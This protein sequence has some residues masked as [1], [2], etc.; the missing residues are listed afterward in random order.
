MMNEFVMKYGVSIIFWVIGLF[1]VIVSYA[2][3]RT[4]SS[5]VPIVGGIII[6]IGGLLSPIKWLA[7]LCFVDYGFWYFPIS[8]ILDGKYWKK[9]SAR[10]TEAYDKHG[11]KKGSSEE[12]SNVSIDFDDTKELVL[13][14]P[15]TKDGDLVWRYY[16]G[17]CY[18]LQYPQITFV[19]YEDE[20]GRKL[21]LVDDPD[22]EAKLLDF[23]K[24]KLFLGRYS[25]RGKEYS[26]EIEVR[27]SEENRADNKEESKEEQEVTR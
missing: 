21:I 6:L 14:V 17:P 8:F 27:K 2:A 10:I 24:D 19:I 4:K 25:R 22:E 15:E 7:L 1:F 5:G 12:E 11:L 26:V 20:N 9:A 13:R 18:R 3:T 23:D 16:K